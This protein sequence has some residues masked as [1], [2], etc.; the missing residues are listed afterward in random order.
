[1]VFAEF[2]GERAGSSLAFA[3]ALVTN[4]TRN[5]WQLA[6]VGP[7][8]AISQISLRRSSGTGR[9]C[10]PL[11]VLAFRKRRSRPSLDSGVRAKCQLPELSVD[12]QTCKAEHAADERHVLVE[13]E[14]VDGRVLGLGI[15]PE[16][17]EEPI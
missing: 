12:M 13:E 9:L 4:T 16:A 14:L 15:A 17:M 8:R 3:S 5:G 1:M 11:R 6:L 7:V 2:P 10:Q